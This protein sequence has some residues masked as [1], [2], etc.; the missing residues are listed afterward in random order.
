MQQDPILLDGTTEFRHKAASSGGFHV[1][2]APQYHGRHP[3]EVTFL[4][5]GEGLASFSVTVQEKTHVLSLQ[6]HRALFLHCVPFAHQMDVDAAQSI[7]VHVRP[8]RNIIFTATGE[9]HRFV[10]VVYLV[11]M[12]TP[13]KAQ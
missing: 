2:E 5:S 10:L 8:A 3:V 7:V 13:S 9:V 11:C 4:E 1:S 12:P 6:I